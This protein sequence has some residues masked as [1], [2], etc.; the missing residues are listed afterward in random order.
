VSPHQPTKWTPGLVVRTTIYL[1]VLSMLL[2]LSSD[3]RGAVGY[4]LGHVGVV[5]CAVVGVALSGLLMFS[6]KVPRR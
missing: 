4:L 5:V 3:V 6:L 1:F 2:M